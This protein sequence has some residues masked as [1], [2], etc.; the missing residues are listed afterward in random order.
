VG[1][2]SAL[3]TAGPA[4]PAAAAA[5]DCG[6]TTAKYQEMRQA[7]LAAAA[8]EF[9]RHGLQAA[10]L[11]AVVARVGL[12]KAS[13]NYYYRRKHDLA[14]DTM[15]EAIAETQALVT[16]ALQ[17]D[18]PARQIRALLSGRALQLAEVA[19]GRRREPLRFDEVRSLA[20]SAGHDRVFEAYTAM[21]RSL[22]QVFSAVGGLDRA[23]CNAR[24]HLLLTLCNGLHSWIDRFEPADYL[25]VAEQVADMLVLGLAQGPMRWPA[26][27]DST[28][29]NHHDNHSDNHH[30]TAALQ[31]DGLGPAT[32]SPTGEAFL[33][34]QGPLLRV[35]ARSAL[36]EAPRRE[37]VRRGEQLN[38]GLS[39]F[40]VE[41]MAQGSLRPVDAAIAAQLVAGVVNAASEL[42]WWVPG[43]NA[44]N[45]LPLYLQPLFA[46]LLDD[47]RA[48]AQADAPA[49]DS[50]PPS[51]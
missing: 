27:H 50:S 14:C 5:G 30:D 38:Q 37:A 26:G 25:R 31:A 36:A 51:N 1:T 35:T 7:I 2:A 8:Q 41:A 23:Q 45:V 22:R 13:L 20:D 33:R 3:L 15:L 4:R 17:A 42:R 11:A 24:T 16:Q 6:K 21:F 46:G 39:L 28:N 9:N 43:V 49:D 34:G 10:T 29:D 32:T 44:S 47:G 19:M 48:G 12:L 40:V 18:G